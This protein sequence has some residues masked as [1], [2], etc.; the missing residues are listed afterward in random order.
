MAHETVVACRCMFSFESGRYDEV[1]KTEMERYH[2]MRD[3]SNARS[4]TRNKSTER[5]RVDH[6]QCA[7]SKRTRGGSVQGFKVSALLGR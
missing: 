3:D 5:K 7:G 1:R 6:H 2:T 4:A